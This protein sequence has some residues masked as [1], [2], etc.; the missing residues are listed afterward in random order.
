MNKASGVNLRGALKV[1]SSVPST[2]SSF[3]SI[4]RVPA[5]AD[6]AMAEIKRK[7]LDGEL[8]PFQRL[9]SEK[10]LAEALGVSRPTVREAVRGLTTL[11][12]LEVRHGDGTYV[13]SLEPALLA[14]PMDFLFK[15]EE[16]SLVALTEIRRVLETGVAEL[17]AVKASDT[18]I[19]RLFVLAHQYGDAIDD[20]DR[21]IELDLQFHTALAEAADSPI[22]ASM[23]STVAALGVSSRQRTAN[24]KGVRERSNLDHV[25]ISEA[26]KAGDPAAAREAMFAHLGHVI[27]A[28]ATKRRAAVKEVGTKPARRKPGQ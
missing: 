15:I 22:L 6:E 21:C 17:A 27:D 24:D 19:S 11:N 10:D 12:I 8:G 2:A 7:I 14:A 28:A 3:R 9:P 25:R 16:T 23:L 1:N 20:I 18:D 26:V 5:A 13:T 4:R